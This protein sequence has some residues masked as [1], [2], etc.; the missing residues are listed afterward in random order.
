MKK[1]WALLVCTAL[2]IASISAVAEDG[3]FTGEAEGYHGPIK[4]EVT[5]K[6][7]KI[8]EL[9]LTGEG[10]TPEIG[11]AALEPLKE[12]ILSAGTVEGVDGV[13]GATW[14]SNGVFGAVK[15]ALGMEEAAEAEA[16]AENVSVSGLNHGLGVVVTPRLGP[17]KDDQE[18]PVYS[19]NVV[20]AYAATDADGR[21]VDLETDILEIIT[22]N[23]DGAEDNALAGWPGA[24]Y[25]N[26]SDGDGKVDGVMEQTTD[27][28]TADLPAWKTKRQLGSAYKMNSGTWTQ[29]MDTFEAF[30]KGKTVEE[31]KAF[32]EKHCS[33]RNGRVIFAG[34]TN[35]EDLAKW[36]TLTAEEQAQVDVLA[37]ATM[38]LSDAHGDILGAIEMALAKQEPVDASEVASLGLGVVITPRLGPGKDDQE[39]PV[40]SFNVVISGAMFDSASS[41]VAA[42][43]DILEIITPN[44][45]GADDNVF[46]GWPGQ[47]YNSDDDGDGKVDRVA[48]QTP[49]TFTEMLGAF[50]TKR[51]LGSLYK[52]NSG[53]WT[54]EMDIFEAFFVGKTTE[55]IRA[56]FV[57][58]CSDRNGR[59]IFADNTNEQ[60][61]AKW[62]ALT[63]EEK[64]AVDAVAGATMSLSDGHG[65]LL[66]ALEKAWQ[67][68][69]SVQ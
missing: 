25:N 50:R 35:E 63:D 61:L 14:T 51:D 19:F 12:A 29:E 1:I 27:N 68:A 52:M 38:S 40:Y 66:G 46:I 30:F 22:P 11:G 54:Q 2:L 41:I 65:D 39:V 5:V 23:H 42:Q 43:E 47:Q 58:H 10:E 24:T 16:D 9:T 49:E 69:K 8:V 13:A 48:E 28:F 67:D 36:N 18:V 45:D 31:L 62:N 21:I 64:A 15:N 56:F 34:N 17:G 53:T 26:D 6:D 32:F 57:K 33:D 20:M 4:A 37:G 55:E 44:H 59:V 7:G 60:D 3:V